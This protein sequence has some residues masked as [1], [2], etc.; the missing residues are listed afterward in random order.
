[1]TPGETI[2]FVV[3]EEKRLRDVLREADVAPLLTSAVKSGIARV[4]IHDEKEAVLFAFGGSRSRDPEDSR[5]ESRP[6][7]LEGEP[8]GE[9]RFR[10][11]AVNAA[12]CRILAGLVADA[13]NSMLAVNL[14]RMLTTEIHTKVVNQSYEE[15]LES[16]RRLV[17]SEKEYRDLAETLEIRV[18]ERTVELQRATT[19]MI[20]Q[21]KMASI[22]QLAAG[23]AHEI[24]NPLGFVLSNL[25]TLEKYVGRFAAMLAFYR[26][27]GGA[28][29]A[30]EKK[31]RELKLDYLLQDV[32]DLIA[33]SVTGAERVK[34]I[35]ADLR[36]FSHVDDLGEGPMDLNQEIERTLGVLV[37]EIPP[38]ARI[39]RKFGTL[40]AMV[41]H[42][43]LLCQVFLNIVRNAFQT[44][45]EGLE[46]EIA[47]ECRGDT[48]QL[49]FA[50]NGPGVPE[51]IKNRI[52]EPFFTTRQIGRGMG[53]GLTVVHDVVTGLGGTVQVEKRPAGGAVFVIQLPTGGIANGQVR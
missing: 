21:E 10:R 5:D 43:G 2:E 25:H 24:N 17:Q 8:V 34:K 37:H 49:L 22:G 20:Q 39:E 3:G 16:N 32:P 7:L 28:A 50:D 6:L 13:V 36:G 46:L 30:G 12:G 41:G 35:V 26:E 31:W 38:G 4:A 9:I 44:R 47:T 27:A 11:G 42:G 19:Q 14:K 40:P 52:F 33:Q 15:L 53:M 51:E 29:E 1:M 18:R 48:V 45:P 23:V